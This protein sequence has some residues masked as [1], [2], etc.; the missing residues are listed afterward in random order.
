M[1]KKL[2]H[3]AIALAAAVAAAA[4]AARALP[5]HP[6]SSLPA[7]AAF[8][9]VGSPECGSG[10]EGGR[11]GDG[12]QDGS[13]GRPGEPGKPGTHECT[14]YSDLPDKPK[15]KLTVADKVRVVLVLM[16]DGATEAQIAEKYKMSPDTVRLWKEAYL[17]RDWPVL[18]NDS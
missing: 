1:S 9:P 6:S 2:R 5:V 15:A 12:G 14:R 7:S 16:N 4:A 17:K 13:P 18:M 11:G 10:G 8:G 3:R